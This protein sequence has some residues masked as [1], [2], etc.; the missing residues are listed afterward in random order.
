M[1]FYKRDKVQLNDMFNS[2]AVVKIR[3]DAV[4]KQASC[5]PIADEWNYQTELLHKD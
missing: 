2:E 1:V 3:F 4:R 5:E